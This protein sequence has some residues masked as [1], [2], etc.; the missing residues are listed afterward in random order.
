MS[1]LLSCSYAYYM[2]KLI[3]NHVVIRHSTYDPA[4]YV[5]PCIAVI[6]EWNN[7]D[8]SADWAEFRT[9]FP[10]RPFCLLV[11]PVPP[12]STSIIQVL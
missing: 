4:Q 11:P 8:Y 9:R 10:M 5:A 3:R 7:N 2:I 1:E 6:N 12:S